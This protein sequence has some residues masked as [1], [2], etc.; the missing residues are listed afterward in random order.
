VRPY[1][2]RLAV[3]LGDSFAAAA[4]SPFPVGRGAYQ[5]SVGDIDEDGKPD[6]VTSSFE[7][8]SMSVLLGR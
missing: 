1:D 6:V 4:G 8:D 3:L 5:L 7:G 2:S